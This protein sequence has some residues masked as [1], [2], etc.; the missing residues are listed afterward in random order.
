MN[1]EK[2]ANMHKTSDDG[3]QQPAQ[4]LDLITNNPNHGLTHVLVVPN[5]LQPQTK[6]ATPIIAV[7]SPETQEK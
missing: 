3:P 7:A 4:V 1:S 2:N 5:N 6:I